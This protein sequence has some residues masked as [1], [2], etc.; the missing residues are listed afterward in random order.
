M[1]E[2]ALYGIEQIGNAITGGIQQARTKK[3]MEIQQRN[4]QA[5]MNQQMQNQMQLNTQGQQIQ[6]D[7]W[8]K[9]NYPA[10]IEM[11]KKAGLNPALI[12]AKGGAGGTTGG[13]GGGSAS[14]GSASMGQAPNRMPMN[15]SSILEMKNLQ[16]QGTLLEA[17]TKKTNAEANVIE[18]TGVKKAETEIGQM[19]AETENTQVKTQLTKVQTALEQIKTSNEQSVIDAGLKEVGE[20]TRGL[21]IQNE[22]TAAQSESLIKEAAA[23]AVGQ[24]FQ[25]ELTKANINMA[26]AETDAIATKIS[27][28]WTSLLLKGQSIDQETRKIDQKDKEILIEKFKAE[29]A[30][31]Y[32]S[33]MNVA[34]M[35]L[36][37][38]FKSLELL[39]DPTGIG[40]AVQNDR[41]K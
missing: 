19:I 12:Y 22:I 38:A 40:S 8:A 29:I 27:Q 1:D 41:V 16:A 7:T 37:K 23:R 39:T 21:K 20:R 13:Q 11:L 15:I 36:K 9:T 4:Q 26:K 17:Q 34:G 18:T 28:E 25:N 14:G 5:L 6:L 30:A 31:E 24:M 10:Q 32:P 3:L 35:T 2:L 33:A